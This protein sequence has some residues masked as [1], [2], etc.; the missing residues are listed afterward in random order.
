MK[1]A[2]I[3]VSDKAS[4]GERADTSGPALVEML[5]ALGFEVVFTVIVPDEREDIA[6]AMKTAADEKGASVVLS[7]GGTGLAARDVT[8]E[9]TRL[10][11]EREVPGIPEALRA[12]S[13]AITP[14]G[15]LSRGVAGIRGSSLIVNLPGSEK[16]ARENMLALSPS[17]THAVEMLTGEEHHSGLNHR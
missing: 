4:K 3:T 8:P 9:A 1:A 11:I 7:T 16:A 12:A 5:E 13:F 15:I 6:E 10:V 17:L 14:A 2:V